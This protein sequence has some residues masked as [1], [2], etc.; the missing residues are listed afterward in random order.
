MQQSHLE[1]LEMIAVAYFRD[2]CKPFPIT[3]LDYRVVYTILQL[4]HLDAHA[5]S[6]TTCA[7]EVEFM[8]LRFRAGRRLILTRSQYQAI[9][10]LG[11]DP[12]VD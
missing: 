11:L 8:R 10:A 12:D 5:V 7:G 6:C 1:L 3:V 2:H 9:S 4:N